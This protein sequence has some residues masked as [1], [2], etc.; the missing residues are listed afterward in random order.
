MTQDPSNEELKALVI[1]SLRGTPN[2]QFVNLM[3]D[4]ERLAL[5][6]GFYRDN[7]IYS[8]GGGEDHKMPRSDRQ[9]IIHIAWELILA[10][11][12]VPGTDEFN[13]N[14]PFIH[15]TEFGKEQINQTL[16]TPYDPDNFLK[17][18]KQLIPNIDGITYFY[19]SEALRCYHSNCY[20]ASAVMI[21]AASENMILNLCN[22]LVE[23][24][25]NPTD[26]TAYQARL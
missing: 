23:A 19:L 18:V 15:L 21:G 6:K 1:E 8:F 7:R 26:N 11:I 22:I 25:H 4:V 9:K 20:T 2:T 16:P 5:S 24:F 10:K 14:L 3:N 12:L 13:Y 17:S